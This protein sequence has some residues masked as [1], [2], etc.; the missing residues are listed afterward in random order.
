MK[1]LQASA[2]G[3]IKQVNMQFTDSNLELDVDAINKK[4]QNK[5]KE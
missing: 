2:S 5:F 1:E 4:I 3:K